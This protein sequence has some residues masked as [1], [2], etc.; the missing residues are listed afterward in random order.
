MTEE[1]IAELKKEIDNLSYIEMARLLRFA[2]V[3]HPYFVHDE[4]GISDYFLKTFNSKGG[5][6]SEISKEIGWGK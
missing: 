6:T 1:K 4:N 2:P 5:M 3:G